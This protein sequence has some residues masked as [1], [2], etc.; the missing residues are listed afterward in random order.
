MWISAN[1][2][3][4]QDA[5]GLRRRALEA[6]GLAFVLGF[7]PELA[8]ARTGAVLEP[9]P[10]WI[11]VLVLAARY[12][13]GGFFA[14]LIAA[15]AAAGIGSAL[16]GAGLATSWKHLGSTPN[17]I[18][19]GTCLTVSGV[20]SWH[21]RRLDDLGERLRS[22]SARAADAEATIETL[23]GVVAKLRARIDR[24]STSLSFLRDVA[25]RLEGSDPVDAAQ[26]AVDLALART[27]ATAAAVQVGRNGC[28]RFVA[29]RDGR[30]PNM[31]APLELR[32]ATVTVPIRNG[33][34]RIGVIALWGIT[35]SLLDDATV[36]DLKVVASW[37]VS[38]IAM[39][40][41]C[42]EEVSSRE[43][44]VS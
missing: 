17:L 39:A 7:L 12:G 40:G 18:A 43:R 10:A 33:S 29:V 36:H 35:P 42:S 14:G 5:P 31:L 41:W 32:D 28:Q 3:G 21:L 23:R 26:G 30:G 15:A 13:S 8:R 1:R 11:A 16:A 38:A 4:R 37:C 27:G 6:F 44:V 9:H 22:V 20:G 25:A 19:F 24:R 2:L 34:D